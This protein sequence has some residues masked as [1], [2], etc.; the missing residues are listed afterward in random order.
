M[1]SQ[2]QT[3]RFS[4]RDVADILS[5][6]ADILQILDAN[7]FRIIAFQN[8]AEAIRTYGQ[9]INAVHAAGKLQEIPGV[10]KGIAGAI[11]E[12]L[13]QGRVAEFEELKA[14]V[15]PGVVEMIHVPD[16]G[17]KTARRLWQELG[18]T[19]VEELRQ[20]AEA[21]RIR[22]LKGFG[23]KSEQKILKGIELW[24]QRGGE[25]RTP[26]GEARPLALA[27]VEGLHTAASGAIQQ[28]QVAGSLRRW[29][30]TI[31]DL[32]ILCVSNDPSTVMEAFRSLPQVSDVV[33]S[34]ETKTSVILTTG[35]RADLRVVEAR[36]WGAAL[37]YF[38]GS[39]EHNVALRELALRQ[40]WSLN[41]YGL[42][43]TGSG[44]EP[45]GT[46]R[47]FDT[48]EALYD[49]LGLEW[50]PPE[51]RENRGEI[52]AARRHE[53]PPLITLADIQ[54]ELHGHTTWSDGTASI[55]EMAE[56]ARRRGY[57]YW[58]V[59]DHS[60]GLG[61]VSGLDAARLA[62][63]AR[64]IEQLNRQW[65][66]EGVDFR[67]LR[68][69]EVEILADGSLA[70]PDE[71]LAGL[72]V[73]VASIH[74]GLRQDRETITERCLRAVRNP[75]VDILG[76]PTGRLLGSRLPSAL[77]VERVLQA[78]AETG[79]VVE[80][81]AHPSRLDLND[82]YARRAMELGC[83][84]AINSDAHAPGGMEI[85]E[86]GIGVARRAW[87]RAEDVVNTRPLPEMLAL[88][89]G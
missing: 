11:A 51:L 45:E 44:Q 32:D 48:E 35:L 80:I 73:V 69:I 40:G 17:P 41:E 68:G 84:L 78:C 5:E 1:S 70:L 56:A 8:A 4:N 60:V 21:G 10:G 72:D 24:S 14:Q 65:E 15:P 58:N 38:T 89:K 67:L 22:E 3:T 52:Q 83:K 34:G 31:G 19:S 81:N 18:I 82:A 50:I 76:H 71:V 37:Q 33:G 46:Q 26:L 9:D 74:S 88:L 53:L 20:A 75:H 28:I 55:A 25:S 86:Y 43:A 59:S 42:T 64:E 49:F 39:K 57:R 54:G 30:E 36:H 2:S 13:E 66:A 23:A 7:R 87:L 77:D 16:V 61:M 62:E 29:R 63:Q 79:T 6:V 27:L 47:F 85:L 12:L